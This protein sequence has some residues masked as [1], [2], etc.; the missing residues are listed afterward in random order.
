MRLFTAT[1]QLSKSHPST[2]HLKPCLDEWGGCWWTLTEYWVE[3]LALSIVDRQQLYDG[4]WL[5]DK[6]VSTVN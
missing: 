5:T 3:G 1:T 6:H 4:N 2:H